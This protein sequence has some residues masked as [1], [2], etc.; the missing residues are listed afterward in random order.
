MLVSILSPIAAFIII[1]SLGLLEREVDFLEVENK[2]AKLEKELHQSK[3]LQ[4]SQ[5]IHPHFLFNTL[6]V[7]LSLG[8]LVLR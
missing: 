2:R 6:N 3:F 8:R 5:Q 7:I 1:I 4:L